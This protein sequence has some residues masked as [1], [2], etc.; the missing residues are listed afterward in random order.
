MRI[1]PPFGHTGKVVYQYG[2]AFY[3]FR[4]INGRAYR[5]G[6]FTFWIDGRKSVTVEPV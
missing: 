4:V 2:H 6:L 1:G 5:I 3:H